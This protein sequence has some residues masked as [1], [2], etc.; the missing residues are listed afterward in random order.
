MAENNFT[1]DPK[2]TKDFFKKAEKVCTIYMD[3]LTNL[4]TETL[5][6]LKKSSSDQLS[7]MQ[8]LG[9]KSTNITPENQSQRFSEA[10]NE[11]TQHCQ[12]NLKLLQNSAQ[13]I[14]KIVNFSA[15]PQKDNTSN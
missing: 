12:E 1:F 4:T 8:N 13:E 10:C 14:S 5:N 9:E 2:N 3:T 6:Y 15:D 11:W 7:Y